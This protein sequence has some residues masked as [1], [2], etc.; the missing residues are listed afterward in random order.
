MCVHMC[1]CVHVFVCVHACVSE[2]GYIHMSAGTLAN[3]DVG[4]SWSS[5]QSALSCHVWLLGSTLGSS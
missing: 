3:R 5:V 2:C 4:S 1:M